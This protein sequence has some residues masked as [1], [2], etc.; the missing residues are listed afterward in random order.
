[1]RVDDAVLAESSEGVSGT[2][3]FAQPGAAT[4]S[5]RDVAIRS[6][7]DP[8][9]PFQIS[10]VEA[11]IA[12]IAVAVIQLRGEPT[13]F[14]RILSEVL[15]GLDHLG[16][17]RR[18]V[19]MRRTI[20]PDDAGPAERAPGLFGVVSDAPAGTGAST[21]QPAGSAVPTD[22]AAEEAGP[23]AIDEDDD[24]SAAPVQQG[25]DWDD[26]GPASDPVRRT[27]DIIRKELRRPDHPRLVE[28]DEDLWWLC[29]E[30]DLAAVKPAL[31][32]RVEWGIF[33]LL[34][35]SGGITESA[36][37]ERIGRL[38][39]GPETT[40][41]ELV[42]ACLASYRTPAPSG[43]GL[44]HTTESLQGRYAGHGEV[45]GMLTDFAH[46]LGMRAWINAREQRRRYRGQPLGDLLSE[47]EQRVYL[48]LIAPGP[49]EALDEVDCIW[50]VRGKGAF[51]F[52]VEWMAAMDEAILLRGPRI[53][54]TEAIVR[55]L[56]VPDERAPLVRL[57][58]ARS[59]LLRERMAADNWHILTWSNV[60]R[61]HASKRADLSVLGPLLGLDPGAAGGEDQMALFSG[62]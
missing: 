53:E 45:V 17:L 48:P 34:T 9:G 2:L 44:I 43:D 40:D 20:E 30:R 57:R 46:R 3:Q 31:S 62:S 33:S 56:V 32:E 26:T 21:D 60:H 52:D 7:S 5:D 23:G 29:A 28:I 38:F 35:T 12:D 10:A 51:L 55:F 4:T 8:S 16:H 22:D 36:F 58:L 37:H 19:G 14:D 59:P 1:M 41:A 50:Y 27:L 42:E 54:T 47:P 15:L 39:R 49:Q 61:L 13:R 18:L 6:A 25:I 11:A 24:E